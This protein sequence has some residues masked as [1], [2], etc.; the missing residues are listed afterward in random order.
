MAT[1]TKQNKSQNFANSTQRLTA[2]GVDIFIVIIIRFFFTA[3]IGELWIKSLIV[4]F[5]Q[6][7]TQKFG[8]PFMQSEL[9]HI[10]FFRDHELFFALI[11]FYITVVLV[12]AIYYAYLHSSSWQ[13]TIGKRVVGIIAIKSNGLAMS[14]KRAM[15]YYFLS[16][17]PFIYAAY[18]FAY[19]ASFDV[20]LI[21][22]L[23]GSITNIILTILF[24]AWVQSQYFNQRKST[25]YDLI[26][27]ID[28]KEG[29]IN[30]KYPWEK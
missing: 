30:K 18:I 9:S 10:Q 14:F 26:C 12:G 22:A 6:D 19:M 4:K 5:E 2:L 1:N 28:V 21:G 24:V 3:L 20:S 25:I 29:K 7:F 13:A 11:I 8:T 27:H 17:L 16:I 23:T 15:L